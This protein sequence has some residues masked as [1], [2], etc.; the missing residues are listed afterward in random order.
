MNSQRS[1]LTFFALLGW[2]WAL[3]L[4]GQSNRIIVQV[5]SSAP[6]ETIR[7]TVGNNDGGLGLSFGYVAVGNMDKPLR[8]EGILRLDADQY[9][10]KNGSSVKSYA[11]GF[12][13]NLYPLKNSGFYVLAAPLLQTYRVS[14]FGQPSSSYA[15]FGVQGG[16]GW[17][18]SL[19]HLYSI[20]ISY[21]K[22]NQVES[23]NF[24]RVKYDL[25]FRF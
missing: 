25:C 12:Q 7:E 13:I 14:P 20:E 2:L 4:F 21:E 22:M 5:R 19:G 8:G 11:A 1:L 16:I 18:I 15:S 9:S 6:L 17:A 10:G 3:P 24:S 23:H